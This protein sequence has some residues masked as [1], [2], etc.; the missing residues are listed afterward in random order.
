[1]GQRSLG[2]YSVLRQMFEWNIRLGKRGRELTMLR[3]FIPHDQ[4]VVQS[5]GERLRVQSRTSKLG[6]RTEMIPVFGK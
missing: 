4:D 5:H 1:M 3:A 6:H 2:F